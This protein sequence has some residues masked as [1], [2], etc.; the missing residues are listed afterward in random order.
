[1]REPHFHPYV[2]RIDSG[3][4]P[5]PYGGLCTLA[6][7]KPVIRRI[8]AVEDWVIG[9]TPAPDTHLLIYAMFVTRGLT[10]DLYFNYPEYEIKKP[11]PANLSGDNIYKPDGSGGFIQLQNPAHDHRHCEGDLSTNRVLISEAE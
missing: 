2:L 6:C 4:A 9:T 3:F 5:N 10:F 8:A 11:G 1:M 7:C